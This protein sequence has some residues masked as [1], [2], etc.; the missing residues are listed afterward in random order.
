MGTT[1]RV[2]VAPSE[3]LECMS[4]KHLCV[5]TLNKE[6]IDPVFLW[7]TLLYDRIVRDQAKISGGGAI[8]EGWN[9]AII[10]KLKIRVPPIGLQKNFRSIYDR[11]I[12]IGKDYRAALKQG[13]I[14]FNSLSQRAFSGVL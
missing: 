14:F 4:T 2:A 10:K 13:N 5:L 1:G 3:L 8:M 9:M 7:A 12:K 6:I 11:K